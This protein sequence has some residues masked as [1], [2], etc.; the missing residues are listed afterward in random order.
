MDQEELI[1]AY[2]EGTLSPEDQELFEKLLEEQPEYKKLLEEHKKVKIAV[3]LQERNDLKAFLKEIDQ[4]EKDR[5]KPSSPVKS[6]LFSGIA[7]CL[8]VLTGF[9]LWI[10]LSMNPGKNYSRAIMKL[11]PIW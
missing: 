4:E 1:N 6:W 11:I 8:I 3:T 10:N 2:L 7:A 9:F 5:Q